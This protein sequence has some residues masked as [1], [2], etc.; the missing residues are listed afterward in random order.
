MLLVWKSPAYFGRQVV[1][2]G[3]EK[4]KDEGEE[5]IGDKRSWIPFKTLQN[6]MRKSFSYL[7]LS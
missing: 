2:V 1:L 6:L 4:E 7:F 3:T 5:Q